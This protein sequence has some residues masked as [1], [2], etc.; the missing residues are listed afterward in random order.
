MVVWVIRGL[1]VLAGAGVGYALGKDAGH[2]EL[3]WFVSGITV[4]ILVV[5]AEWLVSSSPIAVIASVVFG[6]FLG[7]V[8]AV[9]VQ[10]VVVMMGE[11]YG[12]VGDQMF[13]HSPYILLGLMLVFIYLC[14]A[15]LY[16]SRDRFRFI[17]P[18]V[19]FRREERGARPVLLDTS[20]IVDGRI[21]EILETRIID[22][23]IIVPHTVLRE[24][25]QIADSDQKLKRDRGRLGLRV[26]NDL[27]A[28]P[29]LDVRIQRLGTERNQPVDEQ[30]VEIAKK[31]SARIVTND[32]NLNRL[33]AFEG[34]EI[35]NLNQLANALKPIAL[36]DETIAVKL[37]KR[38]EQPGQGVGYLD[39]G[40][41]VVVEEAADML[42]GGVDIVVTNTITRDTG[43]MIFGR[44]A[45]SSRTS[46]HVKQP[47]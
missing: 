11:V 6:T 33:A 31:L 8:F 22:G 29:K 30:L 26:L 23:P 20:V 45:N 15:F 18:Y 12:E 40:T 47:R 19:E 21:A 9:A 37:V 17:I 35:I 24:L 13:F 16:R 1:F 10:R 4:S 27:R 28:D 32:F 2:H 38:G 3:A 5:I 41:M 25:H 44:L 7:T 34:V 14:I 43:R 42:G 39:D 46:P 36:P